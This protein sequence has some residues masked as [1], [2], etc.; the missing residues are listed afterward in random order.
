MCINKYLCVRNHPKSW[1][2]TITMYVG[3]D[4]V[5]QQSVLGSARLFFWFHLGSL[6]HL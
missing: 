4:S 1:L 5:S 3:H 2:K 6:R